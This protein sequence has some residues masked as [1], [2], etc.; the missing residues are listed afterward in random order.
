MVRHILKKDWTLL[1]PLVTALAVLQGLLAFARFTAG[2]FLDGLPTV[3]LAVLELLAA[4]TV[5]TLAV[6][7]DP[8]PGIRQDWLVRPISRRDLFL[9]KLQ[10]RAVRVVIGEALRV[11]EVGRLRVRSEPAKLEVLGHAV[12]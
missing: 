9:A 4:A 2:H 5:I 3:P 8:I 10:R 11:A 1:W 12:A 6:H 7:Q